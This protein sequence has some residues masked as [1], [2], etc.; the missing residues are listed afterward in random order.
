MVARLT[1]S[2]TSILFRRCLAGSVMCEGMWKAPPTISDGLIGGLTFYLL[3]EGRDMV[4]VERKLA[5]EEDIHDDSGGPDVDLR[6]RVEPIIS[7]DL[8]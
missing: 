6:S 2:T 8:R 1:G 4:V 5:A 7:T 3:E